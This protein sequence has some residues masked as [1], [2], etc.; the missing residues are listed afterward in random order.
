[1][2]RKN[3][4]GIECRGRMDLFDAASRRLMAAQGL[5]NK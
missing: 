5:E 1:M 3:V 4:E 2:I